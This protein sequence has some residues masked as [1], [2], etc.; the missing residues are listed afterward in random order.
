LHDEGV[1]NDTI[2][3]RP[4]YDEALAAEFLNVSQSTLHWWLEGRRQGSKTY[5]PV[6]RREPTGSKEVTWGEFVEARFLREYRRTHEV[7]LSKIRDFVSIL[8]DSLE[9]AY[10]LASARPWVGPGQ[11]LLIQAQQESEL[12]PELWAAYEVSSGQTLLTHP[13]ESFLERVE[14]D[15]SEVGF[16]IRVHPN[17][18]ESPVVIDPEVRYGTPNVEGIPTETLA[19][20]VM[21]G[22]SV[23]SVAK[24]FDLKL[25]Y[26][27]AALGYERVTSLAA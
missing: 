20:L 16:V 15:D 11:R 1:T 2:L 23:E 26:V 24:D 25:G 22:D 27:V 17:G 21:A 6:L 8:R 7:P 5:A 9:I 14:F 4:L 18:R 12:P 10:P 19:E 3:E 13:S